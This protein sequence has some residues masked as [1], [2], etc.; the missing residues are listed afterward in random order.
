MI[1][2][3]PKFA[4]F[5]SVVVADFLMRICFSQRSDE[6]ADVRRAKGIVLRD[7]VAVFEL[8]F[9]T[10]G[11]A[12]IGKGCPGIAVIIDVHS[13]FVH[14][15]DRPHKPVIAAATKALTARNREF[16]RI[17]CLIRGPSTCDDVLIAFERFVT[18]H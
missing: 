3:T 15:A 18:G 14:D 8:L 17:A 12:S 1:V 16:L 5:S 4:I 2:R 7:V 13:S 10:G 11:R 6:V 9:G